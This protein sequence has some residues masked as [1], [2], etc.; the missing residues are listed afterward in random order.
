MNFRS[1][2]L[3]ILN[4]CV[5][6]SD[7]CFLKF[8]L[9]PNICFFLST[10]FYLKTERNYISNANKKRLRKICDILLSSESFGFNLTKE[11]TRIEIHIFFI[12]II[13]L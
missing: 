13:N 3:H 11:K 1:N 8:I 5:C 4:A 9:M 7:L 6:I 12:L 2:D 10:Y